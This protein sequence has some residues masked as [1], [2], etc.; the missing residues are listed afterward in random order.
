MVEDHEVISKT[1]CGLLSDLGYATFP[2]HTLA[3][4]REALGS[5]RPDCVVLDVMLPDG[6]AH[7]LL[8]ELAGRTAPPPTVILS[9]APRAR[10]LAAN[11]GVPFVSKPI[12]DER[13]VAAVQVAIDTRSK[14]L[15]PRQ[16]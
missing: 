10:N 7:E 5:V 2:A 1:V 8:R 13:L 6:T 4:A 16:V 14:P 15:Q 12:D 9:A 3:G 11:F